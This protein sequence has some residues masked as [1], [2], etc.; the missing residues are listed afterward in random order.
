MKTIWLRVKDTLLGPDEVIAKG[1]LDLDTQPKEVIEAT[2]R[3]PEASWGMG[4]PETM[5]IF[6]A[7]REQAQKEQARGKTLSQPDRS[8]WLKLQ[9]LLRSRGSQ[10]PQETQGRD[11]DGE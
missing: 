5:A 10:A 8:R 2:A 6:L 3:N 4:K 1:V 7:A 9:D 11:P